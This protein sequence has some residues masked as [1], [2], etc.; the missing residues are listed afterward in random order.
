MG[1][2]NTCQA[3]PPQYCPKGW[4]SDIHDLVSSGVWV[5]DDPDEAY[6][7]SDLWVED[8]TTLTVTLAGNGE[9]TA[10]KVYARQ[11]KARGTCKGGVNVTWH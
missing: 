2:L 7:P 5:L 4:F 3:V 9:N 1:H 8:G 6:T 10:E 11:T